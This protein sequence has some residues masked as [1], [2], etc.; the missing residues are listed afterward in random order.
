MFSLLIWVLWTLFCGAA[1][2]QEP[3]A[4]PD[5]ATAAR[6]G[7]PTQTGEDA[8]TA[9]GSGSMTDIHDIKHLVAVPV[10]VSPTVIAIWT[11]ILLLV[12]GAVLGG[13]YLWKK[14]KTPVVEEVE[15]VLS[16][17]DAALSQ[18]QALSP[19][20]E[21]GKLF[22]FRLSAILREYLHGRFGIDGIEMTTE[23]LLPHVEAMSLERALKRDMKRFLVSSDPVKF[24][25]AP[26][27][28]ELMEKDLG[29][30]RGI[31]EKT[32]ATLG[33][34]EKIPDDVRGASE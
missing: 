5:M 9:A 14:R 2:A 20:T 23:E 11:A 21:D 26:T 16:P 28:R 19:D 32:A 25:G 30:V 12:A 17:E 27:R 13:W 29:F 3:Q 34:P 18:L 8:D 15:A 22:Y 4:I 7:L 31:V 24:A 6:Q 33:A 10:P 1:W